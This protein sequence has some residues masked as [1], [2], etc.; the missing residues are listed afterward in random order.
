V[1]AAR[2]AAV[3]ERIRAA[4]ARASRPAEEVTLL[5]VSKTFP[6]ET[7]RE[8]F[9]AGLRHFGENRVQEA[10]AKL[11][12]LED[13]KPRGLVLHL[14]GHLQGNKARKAL[15]LFDH[16]DA[17]DSVELGERLSR[18][19]LEAG[20]GPVRG[21][22]QADL[23]GEATKHGVGEAELLHVL[24]RL[25]RAPGLRL[26]GL[27][28]L[29]PYLEDP[30]EVRPFFR[31][32]RQLRDEALERGLLAGRVLSMGMSHDFEVAVEEGATQVRLGTVL[33]G[34]RPPRGGEGG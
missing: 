25:R 5:A 15:G 24:E 4:A 22:L 34:E 31:R 33:F 26:E 6:A 32:L 21:L 27:M 7:V 8:G 12:S 30:E 29:P 11:P 3:G 1:I 14:V 16:I 20:S 13:L 9:E 2:V 23:A 10:E 18:L 17:I 28:L 19:A